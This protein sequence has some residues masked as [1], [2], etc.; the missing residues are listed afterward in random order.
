LRVHPQARNDRPFGRPSFSLFL[1]VVEIDLLLW[2]DTFRALTLP[3]VRMKILEMLLQTLF[4]LGPV[5]PVSPPTATMEASSRRQSRSQC[6]NKL[7]SSEAEL[8]DGYGDLS[9]PSWEERWSE[10]ASYRKIHGHCYN[11]KQKGY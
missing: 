5:A 11:L 8:D 10:L 9:G 4:G 2:R 6:Q 1:L 7:P 3:S